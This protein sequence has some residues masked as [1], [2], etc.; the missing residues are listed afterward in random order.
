MITR[1]QLSDRTFKE[2]VRII[3]RECG[4]KLTE[5]KKALV[6]S[7]LLK[8]LRKSEFNTYEEYFVY[9]KRNYNKEITNLINC[10]TTNKTDFFREEH[11]FDFLIDSILPELLEENPEEIRIWSAGC[12]TG[13]EPYT[14]A[15]TLL[16]YFKNKTKKINLKIL[17]TDIDTNVLK[18]AQKGIYKHDVVQDINI[19]ILKKYFLRGKDKNEGYLMVKKKVKDLITFRKLNLLDDIFPMKKKFD[20]IFCRNVIIY[21]DKETQ[22]SLLHKFHSHLTFDGYLFLG[23]SESIFGS[24]DLFTLIGKTIFKRI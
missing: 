8:R 15:I 14:I 9:L 5:R 21:F 10:I 18:T 7:R 24:K 4:I 6:Q 22:I 11:H 13:E 16:E 19:E 3:Y 1:E 12:S 2:L 20:I 23:H 17:A